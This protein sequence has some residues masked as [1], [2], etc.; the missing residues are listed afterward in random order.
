LADAP[1]IVVDELEGPRVGELPRRA[2]GGA[3]VKGKADVAGDCGPVAV[4]GGL[5]VVCVIGLEEAQ[6]RVAGGTLDVGGHG[7]CLGPELVAPVR[8]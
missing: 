4:L 5:A 8:A 2:A 3:T 6:L 1:A 7:V